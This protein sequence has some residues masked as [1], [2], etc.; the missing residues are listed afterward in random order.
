MNFLP[1][2]RFT[3]LALALALAPPFATP[4][5]RA[6]REVFQTPNN[7]PNL[8]VWR[9]THEPSLRD[10]ANYHNTQCWS[11]D[12]RYLCSTRSAPR[13]G[14]YG[15][16]SV[17]VY[18]HD[19]QRDE[20][21]LIERGFFPR[22]AKHRNWLFYVRIIPGRGT[23]RQNAVEVRWLDLETGRH[24]T[25][26]S[27]VENLGETSFDDRWLYGAKRFRGQNPEYVTV[28]IPLQP[29]AVT[30]ELRLA[31]GAQLLPNPRHPVFFTRQDHKSEAF[32]ATRWFYDLDGGN[33]RL[34]VPT[35][36]Q[37]HMS[38]LG[39]GEYLLMGNGLVRGRRWN[40]PYPSNVDVLASVTVGDISPCG[41]SGR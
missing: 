41:R 30:E 9:I 32:G 19:L 2:R 28:R 31:V 17:E 11:P 26:A 25:L 3:N 23:A 10:W 35:L 5:A 13:D 34:A 1:V 8:G 39:S 14:R 27:G 22:W 21:R 15:D 16:D 20:T 29:G 40:E 37:C 36:Q 38:W 18:L 6:A 7:G 24:I 33:K 4:P 12:G